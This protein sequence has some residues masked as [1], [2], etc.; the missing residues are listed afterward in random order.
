MTVLRV[1]SYNTRDFLDDPTAAA[2]VVRAIAPDVLCLQEVPR[3][4]WASRKVAAFARSCGMRWI[5]RHRGSGGTTVFVSD[6]VE[7][8]SAR[9]HRLHVALL[10]RTRGYAVA[11]LA[12]PGWPPL[13]VASVHLGLRPSE[14]EEHTKVI[15]RSLAAASGD[16]SIAAGDLNEGADGP[17]YRRFVEPMRPVSPMVPTYPVWAPRAVLDVIF[18]SPELRVVE[19]EP[20]A[21]PEEL[22]R[23]ASDHRPTWVDLTLAD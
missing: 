6:A 1:A 21:L 7:I 12:V 14:R 8:R 13:V 4:L 16:V 17:A 20:V 3:R 22:V 19:G 18:A 23:R 15:L 11:H 10:D 5:G 9:H 2:A